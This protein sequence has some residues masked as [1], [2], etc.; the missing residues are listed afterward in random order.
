MKNGN[1]AALE[2][3]LSAGVD[4]DQVDGKSGRSALFLAVETNQL[5]MAQR[6]LEAGADVAIVNYA[7][8]SAVDIANKRQHDGMVQLLETFG[9]DMVSKEMG[10]RSGSPVLEK[11]RKKRNGGVK[12]QF[13]WLV[14]YFSFFSVIMLLL[15][16]S[17]LFL[18]KIS[19]F[20]MVIYCYLYA[21]S[22]ICCRCL[23][24]L[25][26]YVQGRKAAK[27]EASGVKPQKGT[28]VKVLGLESLPQ[29]MAQNCKERTKTKV[30]AAGKSAGA[31][32]FSSDDSVVI[33]PR[34]NQDLL[35]AS[36]L[37]AF[38][39]RASTINMNEAIK[40]TMLSLGFNPA[41]LSQFSPA[42]GNEHGGH[43]NG[44]VGHVSNRTSPALQSH[45]DQNQ[46]GHEADAE[47]SAGG[48]DNNGA[49]GSS[50]FSPTVQIQA[51]V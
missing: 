2:V 1:V 17:I 46:F 14:F 50:S 41:S 13:V 22:F 3:L 39:N 10:S 27:S 48:D 24:L 43:L 16:V 51:N 35:A 11:G 42:M 6:L 47:S 44:N 45:G 37:T 15:V 21:V 36:M 28:K 4:V 31:T 19:L 32:E 9:T 18:C 8:V 7:G 34:N 49:Y 25:S 38:K 20:R 26:M 29:P 23:V 30:E 12:R 5:S 33:A 40:Q